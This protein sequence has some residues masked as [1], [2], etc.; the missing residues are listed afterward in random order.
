VEYAV[1]EPAAA[2]G[3]VGTVP[4]EFAWSDIGDFETIAAL[5]GHVEA[6]ATVVGAGTSVVTLDSDGLVV[7]PSAGRLVATL[8]VHDLIIVDTPDTVLVCH[9]DR[10]QDVKKLTELLRERGLESYV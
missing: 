9:R 3:R 6:G 2:D 4:G 5:L 7:V 8:D 1:M 10:A